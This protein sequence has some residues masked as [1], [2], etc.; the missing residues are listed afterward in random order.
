MIDDDPADVWPVPLDF[1]EPA[2]E[3]RRRRRV[4]LVCDPGERNFHPDCVLSLFSD[5]TSTHEGHWAE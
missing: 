4:A 2:G 5:V 3:R 1:F